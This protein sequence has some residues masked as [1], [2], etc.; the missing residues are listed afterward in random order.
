MK[1]HR[2]TLMNTLVMGYGLHK[3]MDHFI[4]PRSATEEELELYHDQDYVAFLSRYAGSVYHSTCVITN[5][6]IEE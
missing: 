5:P 3:Y 4:N 2:L 6:S 1:P